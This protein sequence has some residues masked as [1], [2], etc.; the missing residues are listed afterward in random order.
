MLCVLLRVFVGRTVPSLLPYCSTQCSL[1]FGSFFLSFI[2][3]Y[4]SDGIVFLSF[5]VF[6]PVLRHHLTYP[7]SPFACRV[8]SFV[9]SFEN[10]CLVV[11]VSSSDEEGA[12]ICWGMFP[13]RMRKP[14]RQRVSSGT[15]TGFFESD[16]WNVSARGPCVDAGR[17]TGGCGGRKKAL[18]RKDLHIISNRRTLFTTTDLKLL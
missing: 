12:L 18:K 6:H 11:V 17:P 3:F 9:L 4:L 10:F 2:I 5:D 8:I 14:V 16:N 7:L 15:T 13:H 1:L